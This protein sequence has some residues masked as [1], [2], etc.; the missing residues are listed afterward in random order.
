[1][2]STTASVKKA[3]ADEA[4]KRRSVQAKRLALLCAR[5]GAMREMSVALDVLKDSLKGGGAS[6]IA[7]AASLR[8]CTAK[9]DGLLHKK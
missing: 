1:M 9:L 7:D 4:A 2:S 5:I 3:I 6:V 8:K